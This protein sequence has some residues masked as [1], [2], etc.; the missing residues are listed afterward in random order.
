MGKRFIA[1]LNIPTYSRVYVD[2]AIVIYSVEKFPEYFPML[3]PMWLQMH[4]GEIKI[5]SIDIDGS[6]SCPYKK[7]RHAVSQ[8]L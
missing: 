8:C 1:Q 6:Y 5:F 3:Q 4:N 7:Q 2:T